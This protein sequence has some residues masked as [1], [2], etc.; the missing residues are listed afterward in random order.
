MENADSFLTLA[1]KRHQTNLIFEIR[2][3]IEAILDEQ[4]R[5]PSD[6]KYDNLF[7][8]VQDLLIDLEALK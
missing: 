3:R 7:F 2:N 4:S 1:R 6:E 5:T 8:N